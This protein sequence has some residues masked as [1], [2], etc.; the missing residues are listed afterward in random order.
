MRLYLDTSVIGGNYDL[1][2]LEWTRPLISDILDRKYTAVISDLTISEILDGPSNVKLLLEKLINSS[3]ELISIN[4]ETEMLAGYY[5]KEGV[6][7]KKALE[8]ANHIAM[9]SVYK[10]DAVVSWNFK[11]IVNVGRIY[12]FNSV[13][14][15][16]GYGHI[17]IRSPREIIAL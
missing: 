16:Y 4:K 12:K 7:T 1:E 8:D 17:D 11:H 5:I 13:N 6:L 9:A 10:V 3:C 14:L 15:K 2:F